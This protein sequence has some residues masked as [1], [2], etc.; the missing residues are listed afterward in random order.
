MMIIHSVNLLGPG[1]LM[2]PTVLSF[3]ITLTGHK[4]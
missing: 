4:N 2:G 1:E 3:C